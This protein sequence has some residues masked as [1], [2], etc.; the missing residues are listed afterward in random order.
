MQQH[1]AEQ[2]VLFEFALGQAGGEVGTVNRNVEFFEQVRQR[3]EVI[4]VTVR[5]DYGGDI[6]AVLVQKIEVWDR[7]IDAICRLLGKAHPGVEN[8]HLVAVPHRHAIHSKLAD[9]A[10]WD[11][12]ED[13]SHKVQ[14]YSTQFGVQALACTQDSS[15]KAELQTE[16]CIIGVMKIAFA[17]TILLFLFG[18]GAIAATPTMRVDYY[19]TGDAM[20]PVPNRKR[21]IVMA[22]AI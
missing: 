7:N 19:H 9:T 16:I 2:L 10:E 5:E 14:Q 8:Q 18:T 20:A 21:R 13:A 4:F 11:D 15:L 1:V 3:A 12:L 6:V 22:K 17:I